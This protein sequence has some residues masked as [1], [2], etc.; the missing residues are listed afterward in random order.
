M[1]KM[2]L[3]N[4]AKGEAS[5]RGG[6]SWSRGMDRFLFFGDPPSQSAK[7]G[8]ASRALVVLVAVVP[9]LM[10]NRTLL[11]QSG[12]SGFGLQWVESHPFTTWAWSFGNNTL[13]Q[14]DDDNFSN[15]FTNSLGGGNY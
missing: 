10:Q 12:T 11:A 4:Q 2:W 1:D 9:F 13:A 6:Q 3:G 5:M 14:Y 15:L 7:M 8:G